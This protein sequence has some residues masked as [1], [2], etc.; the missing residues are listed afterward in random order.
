MTTNSND[1]VI[2]TSHLGRAFGRVTALRDL[3]LSVPRGS[4]YGFLG[5]NGSGKTTAIKILAGLIRPGGG[6]A[7]VLGRNPFD[8]TIEDRQKIGYLSEKQ[9]LPG[10]FKVS[11]LI[12]FCAQFYPRWDHARVE[13]L[14][15]R[16]H[17]DLARKISDLS[18]GTQRQVAFILALAQRPELLIL[19]EPASTLDVVARREFLDE[20]LDVIRQDGATVFISSHILSDIERVADRIGILADGVLKISEPLDELKETVKQIRF[21]TFT[22]SMAGFAWPGAFR[23]VVSKDEILVTARITGEDELARIARDHGAQYEIIDLALEDIF[24]EISRSQPA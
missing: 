20:I 1:I 16:F 22:Q 3:T 7:R 24:V 21:H 9:I 4:I 2:E 17:I 23:T 8:F 6:E 15:H 12:K 5:R 11:R 14:I 10:N 19:D 13:E 18:Q